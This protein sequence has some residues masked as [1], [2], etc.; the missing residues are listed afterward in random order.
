L[1]HTYFVRIC[2]LQHDS[3]TIV[4]R[5]IKGYRNFV[6]GTV[7]GFNGKLLDYLLDTIKVLLQ[8]QNLLSLSTA[9]PP[10]TFTSTSVSASSTTV[11]TST[12]TATTDRWVYHGA[13]HCLRHTIKTCGFL[14][15]YRGITSPLL[16]AMDK[17]AVLRFGV[18]SMNRVFCGRWV[19][20]HKMHR[21]AAIKLSSSTFFE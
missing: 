18:Q 6:A 5:M 10:A 20:H 1:S 19:S 14:L 11:T 4:K 2:I 12:S 13:I 15:L 8:T 3:S 16:G 7:R 9:T 21:V 17:N